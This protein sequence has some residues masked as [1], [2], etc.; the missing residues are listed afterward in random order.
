MTTVQLGKDVV[1]ELNRLKDHPRQ[2]YDELVREMVQFIQKA[3][4]SGQ[5]DTFLHEAQKVKMTE[6]W[7]NKEDEAWE[8]A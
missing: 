2:S 1:I 8:H 3:K 4:A 5:Y 6:L 7:D